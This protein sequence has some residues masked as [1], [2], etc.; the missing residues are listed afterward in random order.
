[1]I[2]VMMHL[3]RLARFAREVWHDSQRLRRSFPGPAEE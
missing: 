3:A 2:P 1:M